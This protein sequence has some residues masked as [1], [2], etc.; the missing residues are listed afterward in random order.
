MNLSKDIP[1]QDNQDILVE[2]FA[3]SSNLGSHLRNSSAFTDI[4]KREIAQN[5]LEQIVKRTEFTADDATTVGDFIAH[6]ATDEA[7]RALRDVSPHS[8]TL[9][10][11]SY[12]LTRLETDLEKLDYPDAACG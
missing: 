2:C 1:F 5:A 11:N 3:T 10:L 9:R 7:Q 4:E 12:S 6:L 8:A